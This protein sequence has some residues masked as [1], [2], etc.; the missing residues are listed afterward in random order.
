MENKSSKRLIIVLILIIV[1]LGVLCV[2]LATG[3]ISFIDETNEKDINNIIENNNLDQAKENIFISEIINLSKEKEVYDFDKLHLEFNGSK[4]EY[5]ESFYNYY[6]DIKYDD[7]KIDSSIFGIDNDY[8]IYS[9]NMAANFYVYR[10]HNVYILVS[11]IAKQCL[12]NDV[13]IFNTN[14]DILGTYESVDFEI[15]NNKINITSSD[16]NQC[17]GEGYEE[18]LTKHTYSIVND[19]LSE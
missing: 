19:H 3:R 14:G 1:V 16:N 13:V 9:N 12:C 17:M 18:H 15:E 2:L 7:K 6:L 8:R 10:V 5:G 4:S 11:F